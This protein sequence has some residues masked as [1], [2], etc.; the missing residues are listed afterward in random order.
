MNIYIGSDHG[1]YNLKHVVEKHLEE[2][3][4]KR[5]VDL[6]VFTEDSVDYPDIVREVCEKVLENHGA[7]GVLICGTGLGMQMTAAKIKGIRA[8]LCTNAYMAK[9]ARQHND[10]NVLCLGE[11]V[12][13][14]ELA[15]NI[16]NAFFSEEFANEERHVRRVKK[17]EDIPK[18]VNE[19]HGN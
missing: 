9:M 11:R 8:A 2:D 3:S 16:V 13:G 1:G 5:V 18:E 12:V 6:G 14:T 4:E 10:A 15:K 19:K 7:K 17:I